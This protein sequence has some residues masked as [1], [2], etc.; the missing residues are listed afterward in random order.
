MILVP[1]YNN[2]IEVGGALAIVVTDKNG[3]IKQ[4]LY[5]PNLIVTSGKN[6]I[7]SRMLGVG[8]AMSHMGIGTDPTAEVIGNTNLTTE[9]TGG[10]YARQSANATVGAG[11]NAN[12]VQYSTTFAAQ[13]PTTASVILR[14]AGIFNAA[15]AGTMLCRTTFP[16]VTKQAADAITITWTITIS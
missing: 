5:V 10:G 15:T 1:K 13:M 14:E 9:V 3:N 11:A 4:D 7:A 16:A 6:F 12:Q 8:T 2:I